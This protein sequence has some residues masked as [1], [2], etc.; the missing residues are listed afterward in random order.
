MNFNKGG[1]NLTRN[2][3]SASV[4]VPSARS[5]AT[6]PSSPAP[7]PIRGGGAVYIW[8]YNVCTVNPG[9]TLSVVNIGSY[10]TSLQLSWLPG[11]SGVT[12]NSPIMTDASGNILNDAG[13]TIYSLPKGALQSD[14]FIP[15]SELA[16]WAIDSGGRRG[17][18]SAVCPGDQVFRMNPS[19]G[20]YQNVTLTIGR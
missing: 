15:A 3:T 1:G 10:N 6:V 17:V 18:W 19:T 12:A 20:I 8:G 9:G 13:G 14:L 2:N 7:A 16:S 4:P 5:S 11:I